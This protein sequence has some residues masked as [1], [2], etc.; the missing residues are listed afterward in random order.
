MTAIRR[1]TRETR[2]H[3]RATVLQQIGEVS[4]SQLP[5]NDWLQQRA[6]EVSRMQRAYKRGGGH[7]EAR[8]GVVT[9]KPGAGGTAAP[10]P[11]TPF[12][13]KCNDQAGGCWYCGRG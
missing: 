13:N 6:I 2:R 8:M 1:K 11:A 10:S 3:E 5:A 9:S 7:H 4:A 12:C